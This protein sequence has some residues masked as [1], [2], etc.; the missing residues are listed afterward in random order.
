MERRKFIKGSIM[1]GLGLLVPLPKAKATSVVL[2][3]SYVDVTR[4]FGV[5]NLDGLH[6][7]ELLSGMVDAPDFI[8]EHLPYFRKQMQK[9]H[10]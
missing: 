7:H 5:D 6:A 9:Y 1:V 3:S 2:G 8:S 4:G 10:K